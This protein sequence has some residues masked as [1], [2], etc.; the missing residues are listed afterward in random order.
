MQ[1]CALDIMPSD[2]KRFELSFVD[3]KNLIDNVYSISDC[4]FESQLTHARDINVNYYFVSF[5]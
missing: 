1:R 4:E 3:P 5:L 2:Q